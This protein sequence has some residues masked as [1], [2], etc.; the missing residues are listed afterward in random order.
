MKKLI[1]SQKEFNK[2]KTV[3]ENDSISVSGNFILKNSID[4]YGKL[5]IIGEIKMSD[6]Q[7]IFCRG[8]SRVNIDL[9][10]CVQ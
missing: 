8:N 9:C 2:I 6:H 4:V 10:L 3:S 5:T 7:I 1:Q